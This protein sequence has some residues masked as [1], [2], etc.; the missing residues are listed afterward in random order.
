MKSTTKTGR[1]ETR[2]GKTCASHR[3]K[4][5]LESIEVYR[6]EERGKRTASEVEKG[7]KK[8][9]RGS[10]FS[11]GG[12]LLRSRTGVRQVTR[13]KKKELKNCSGEVVPFP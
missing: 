1:D 10:C 3:K 2:Y 11:K 7:W 6:K 5:V 9:R 13:E 8:K 12:E 4:M